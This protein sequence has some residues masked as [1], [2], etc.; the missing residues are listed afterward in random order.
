MQHGARILVCRARM[1][2]KRISLLSR[3][4]EDRGDEALVEDEFAQVSARPE[5]VLPPFI[6]LDSWLMV[7]LARSRPGAGPLDG[8]SHSCIVRTQNSAFCRM[9]INRPCFQSGT[10]AIRLSRFTGSR[11]HFTYLAK[12]ADDT[13]PQLYLRIDYREKMLRQLYTLTTGHVPH[14][15]SCITRPTTASDPLTSQ[16][17]VSALQLTEYVCC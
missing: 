13:I 15:G 8:Y 16:E 6:G 5:N 10:A 3:S 9:T 17:A 2:R 4:S 11:Y 14:S 7:N 12:A 1:L